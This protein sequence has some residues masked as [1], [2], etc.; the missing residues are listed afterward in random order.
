LLRFDVTKRPA[1]N[2]FSR[3]EQWRLL[4]LVMSLGVVMLVMREL[5]EPENVAR[6]AQVFAGDGATNGDEGKSPAE[7]PQPKIGSDTFK[8]AAPEN[9]D[10]RIQSDGVISPAGPKLDELLLL[11]GWT[12]ERF[13]KFT[14]GEP[15]SDAE[16]GELIQLLWR[17]RTFDAALFEPLISHPMLHPGNLLHMKG[18]AR[19][20]VRHELPPEDATRFEMPAY[21]TCDVELE[22]KRSWAVVVTAA[23]PSRWVQLTNLDEPVSASGLYVK[24][25]PAKPNDQGIELPTYLIVAKRIAWHPETPREPVVSLG[26]SILGSLGMDVGLLDQITS[27]GR[28]HT[29]D[30]AEKARFNDQ[31]EAFYQML[32]AAGQIGANQLVRYAN[33]NLETI[34]AQWEQEM[35]EARDANRRALAHEVI[36]RAKAGRYSV[37]PLFNDA[38]RQ[39]GQ[40]IVV[41]GAARRVVRVD[42]SSGV[43]AGAPSDVARRFGIDHYYE[44]QVFTDDSQNYPLVFCVRE[45]PAG[46][47]IGDD[48]HVPVRV[49]GFFFKDWL[50]TTRGTRDLDTGELDP[51]NGRQQH[52]PLLIGRAPILLQV[53]D[54]GRA[55]AQ[56]VGGGLFLLALVGIWGAAW[57]LSR[58]DRRFLERRRKAANALPPGQSLDDL[59]LPPA[60]APPIVVQEVEDGMKDER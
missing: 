47:P 21:Y 45:L 52:A 50:Y 38:A 59:N 9:A 60:D 41:D 48:L 29:G 23:A 31:R 26:M 1:R 40:L 22:N 25:L 24:Q 20:F 46:L 37:A 56:L 34:R 33:S 13:A 2:Y 43:A 57:W 44:M 17:V 11:A 4:L 5:R 58:S 39:I 10:R 51:R 8:S 28:L 55:A 36:E 30:A 32:D 49:A 19:N 3:R 12:P 53:E 35:K 16:R 6:V 18:Q 14:H 42:L 15:L 54:T 7:P 27:R